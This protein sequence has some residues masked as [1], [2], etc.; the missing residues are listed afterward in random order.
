MRLAIGEAILF[1]NAIGGKRKEER[2]RF[3]ARHWM[4]RL[5]ANPRVAFNTSFEANQSCGLGN[6]RIDGVDPVA[7]GGYLMSKH[8]IFTTPIVHDE[9]KGI[10]ITPSVYTTLW[11]IDRFCDVVEQVA[12]NGLPKA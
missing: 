1:H 3:L 4:N 6:F 2:L 12:K 9:F 5:K 8:K 7:L 10:R 11:E